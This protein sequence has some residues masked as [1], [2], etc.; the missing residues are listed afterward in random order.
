MKEMLKKTKIVCTVGPDC[1]N[2]ETLKKMLAAG[3]NVARFN[4]SHGDHAE[5][6]HQMDL[7]K[8][9]VKQSGIPCAYLLDTKGPEI[10]TGKLK[11]GKKIILEAGKEI[12][13]TVSDYENFEG[14][15][16]KLALSYKDLPKDINSVGITDKTFVYIA[17]GVFKLKVL[18]VNGDEIKCRI[19]AGGELGQRKNVNVV[20]VHTNL[21]AMAEKD[22]ADLKMGVEN[23]IHF[24]AASFIRKASDVM[25]MREYLAGIKGKNDEVGEYDGANVKIISKIEDDEGLSNIDDIIRVSDGIM[26]ARGDLGVQIPIQ[27]IPLAQKKIIAKCNAAG[28]PVITA[29]QMLDS[30]INNPRPTRAESNDVANAIFDGTDAVMLSGETANGKWPVEAVTTMATIAKTIENASEYRITTKKYIDI[31]PAKNTAEATAKATYISARDIGAEVII[32]PTKSGNTAR[33]IS[34]F[35]PEQIIFA[36]TTSERVA[37]QLMIVSGVYPEVVD[38]IDDTDALLDKSINLAIEKGYLDNFG[39]AVIL[40]GVP[41]I[42]KIH[43]ACKKQYRADKGFGDVVAGKIVKA[44]NADEAKKIAADSILLTKR[45]DKSFEKALGNAKAIILEEASEF[46]FDVLKKENPSLVA[47]VSGVA[48]ALSLFENGEEVVVNGNEMSIYCGKVK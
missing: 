22:K 2:V 3:M 36:P 4:F 41:N 17:D 39:K 40:A 20:G 46:S 25:A 38:V 44:A 18:E 15:P 42:M 9:A 28:K 11:D 35:R 23:G 24:V 6:K 37:R 34:K 5:K 10:R 31:H 1:E 32:A 45:L 7:V 33:Q 26:V 16:E 48:N 21:P 27:D 8:E 12:I 13:L 14:T 47:M 30:M 43:T 29:T 19:E